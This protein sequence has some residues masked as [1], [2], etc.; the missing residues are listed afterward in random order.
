MKKRRGE[1]KRGEGEKNREEKKGKKRENNIL[2]EKGSWVAA[3]D[4]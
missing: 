1:K 3:L 2:V 4:G